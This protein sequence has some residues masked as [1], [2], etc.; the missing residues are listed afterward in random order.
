MDDK[1][2]KQAKKR[3]QKES[4]ERKT[5]KHKKREKRIIKCRPPLLQIL[6]PPLI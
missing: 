5:G 2:G 6:F 4:G 3:I 1:E